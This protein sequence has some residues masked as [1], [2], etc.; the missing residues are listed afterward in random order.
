MNSDLELHG[1]VGDGRFIKSVQRVLI[2][3]PG[4]NL[5]ASA[6]ISAVDTS[7]TVLIVKGGPSDFSGSPGA[8][9]K[10]DVRVSLASSTSVTATRLDTSGGSNVAVYVEIVEFQKIKSRQTGTATATP[11]T[12]S[13]VDP[14]KSLCF[15]SLNSSYTDSGSGYYIYSLTSATEIT[16]TFA[17]DINQITWFVVEF[18]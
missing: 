18:Y 1:L 15:L 2:T 17:Y 14:A 12:I 8:P 6:D 11:I 7:K 10:Y 16:V 13:T 3:I 4:A 5:N 9:D